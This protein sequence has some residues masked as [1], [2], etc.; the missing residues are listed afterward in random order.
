MEGRKK[1]LDGAGS[2]AMARKGKS[3]FFSDRNTAVR[4]AEV[5]SLPLNFPLKKAGYGL[6]AHGNFGTELST[7]CFGLVNESSK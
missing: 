6:Q 1:M 2:G 7:C 3:Y 5:H 4:G